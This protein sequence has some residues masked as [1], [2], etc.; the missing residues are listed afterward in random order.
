MHN[1]IKGSIPIP[2]HDIIKITEDKIRPRLRKNSMNIKTS[3]NTG[4]FAYDLIHNWQKFD[5]SLSDKKDKYKYSHFTIKNMIKLYLQKKS[6][7]ECLKEN[8]FSCS[9]TP[10]V[11]RLKNYMISPL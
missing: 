8:C 5:L 2:I 10:A 7:R 11:K 9:K 1:Y 6:S 3:K 4:N